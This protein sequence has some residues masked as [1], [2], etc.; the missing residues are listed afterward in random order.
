MNIFSFDEKTK[1]LGDYACQTN[2]HALKVCDV[3]V[4]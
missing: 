2:V 3:V 1:K 4:V